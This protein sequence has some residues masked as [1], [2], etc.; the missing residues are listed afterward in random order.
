MDATT[1]Y[2]KD[3]LVKI[4][5]LIKKGYLD[6]NS[7]SKEEHTCQHTSEAR[8]TLSKL[9]FKLR[10]TKYAMKTSSIALALVICISECK[11]NIS[12]QLSNVAFALM[13]CYCISECKNRIKVETSP[14][15]FLSSKDIVL[16]CT[17]MSAS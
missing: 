2:N 8:I 9:I 15:L 4:L 14:I 10:I 11:H 12:L 5:Y 6:K 1:N 16:R 13:M 3:N 17:A 7:P